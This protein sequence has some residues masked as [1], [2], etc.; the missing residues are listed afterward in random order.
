M[1]LGSMS[2]AKHKEC[3][4]CDRIVSNVWH[5]FCSKC[6]SDNQERK[7]QSEKSES[8]KNF[9]NSTTGGTIKNIGHIN[10]VKYN[11]TLD[12]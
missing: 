10:P 2:I 5:S 6:Y 11:Q 4:K 1:K 8:I 7:E 3:R 9:F 12:D